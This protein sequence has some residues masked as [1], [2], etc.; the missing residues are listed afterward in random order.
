MVKEEPQNGDM[1]NLE[2][3][4]DNKTGVWS[5]VKN[6]KHIIINNNLNQLNNILH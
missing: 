5:N 2:N 1:S 4:I 6:I 3:S